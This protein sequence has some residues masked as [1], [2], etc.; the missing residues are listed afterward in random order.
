MHDAPAT[1]PAVVYVLAHFD[2]E[3]SALPL[4]RRDLAA[5]RRI[6]LVHLA[7]YRTPALAHRRHAET[8]A[9]LRR[10]GAPPQASVHLGAASGWLDGQL[11]RHAGAAYAALKVWA[12]G[13]GPI[14]RLVTPAWEGGHPDH[15][16]CA[17]LGAMLAA[18]LGGLP[19]DQFSLYQGRGLP[20]PLYHASSP[21]AENGPLQEIRLSAREW[22]GWLGAV[23]A[24]PSQLHV[25]LG[26]VPAMAWSFARQR[27]VRYQMLEPGRTHE[28]PHAG[29]LLYERTFQVPYAAIRN[30]VDQVRA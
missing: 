29:L 26:Q 24:F 1:S 8:L 10:L 25:W 4:I 17:A 15:D 20:G 19:V 6:R 30:A 22:L 28:R 21:L 9:L 3:F 5:G 18:E 12:A 23:G 27:C 11:H 7:D 16:I 2:D 13:A 14:D